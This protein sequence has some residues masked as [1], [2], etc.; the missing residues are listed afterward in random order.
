[1]C[2]IPP[3]PHILAQKSDNLHFCIHYGFHL[4]TLHI[5]LEL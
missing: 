2:Y 3:R 4:D 1:M 5:S